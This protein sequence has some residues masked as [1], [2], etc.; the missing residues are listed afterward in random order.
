[1]KS[2]LLLILFLL[3]SS[4]FG[5][6]L[7]RRFTT[8]SNAPLERFAYGTAM[9]LGVGALGVFALGMQWSGL[10]QARNR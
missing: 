5:R 8:L 9:G 6:V 1:M 7:L 2:V 4:G 3:I 10:P